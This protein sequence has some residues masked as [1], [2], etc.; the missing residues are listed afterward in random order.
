MFEAFT[1]SYDDLSPDI[2]RHIFGTG[3]ID[4]CDDYLYED[5]L[6]VQ[7]N[8]KTIFCKPESQLAEGT[9]AIL[10]LMELSYCLL[11]PGWTR[12]MI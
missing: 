4:Y 6:V 11:G 9:Q 3:K 12:D 2:N 10:E 5:Y 1:V 7:R 8:G